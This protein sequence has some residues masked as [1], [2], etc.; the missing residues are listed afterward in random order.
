MEALGSQDPLLLG[1]DWVHIHGTGISLRQAGA[2]ALIAARLALRFAISRAQ[3]THSG[4]PGARCHNQRL[5]HIRL[6]SR[7]RLLLLQILPVLA[8]AALAS[9]PYGPPLSPPSLGPTVPLINNI[10]EFARSVSTRVWLRLPITDA[11]LYR[12]VRSLVAVDSLDVLTSVVHTSFLSRERPAVQCSACIA[13]YLRE[14]RSRL[15]KYMFLASCQPVKAVC[16]PAVLQ[17]M[18]PCDHQL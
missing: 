3:T 10:G 1:L 14:G 15:L 16:V 8:L 4:S 5:L 13:P 9:C 7:I 17:C 18:R 12:W 2:R 11:A 6:P